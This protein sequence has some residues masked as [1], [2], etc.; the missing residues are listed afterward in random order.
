MFAP[1]M[2]GRVSQRNTQLL[3]HPPTNQ[4]RHSS[5]QPHVR[6]HSSHPRRIS[7]QCMHVVLYGTMHSKSALFSHKMFSEKNP[8]ERVTVTHLDSSPS[9]II[10][11]GAPRF[12]IHPPS[13]SFFFLPS[14]NLAWCHSH[15]PCFTCNLHLRFLR[16]VICCSAC[17]VCA[18]V[19]MSCL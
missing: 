4:S 3:R 11:H 1:V 16:V 18:V 9:R 12:P 8:E 6:S 19:R 13:P 2:G 7:S 17:T 10:S 15:I 14:P 5:I